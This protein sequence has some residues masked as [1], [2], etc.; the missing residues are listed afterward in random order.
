M[1]ENRPTNPEPQQDLSEI[2]RIRREKLSNLQA[3]GR[4]PARSRPAPLPRRRY[5]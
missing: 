5:S 4:D 2:L 3:A 1:A